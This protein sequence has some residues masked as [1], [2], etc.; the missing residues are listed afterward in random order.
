MCRPPSEAGAF[1][2]RQL[3]VFH[4]QRTLRFHVAAALCRRP[5]Y[6]DLNRD[7]SQ[8]RLSNIRNSAAGSPHNPLPQKDRAVAKLPLDRTTFE[9][10]ERA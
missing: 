1:G 3:P 5:I 10:S 6:L 8:M 4:K 7:F 9:E 2:L